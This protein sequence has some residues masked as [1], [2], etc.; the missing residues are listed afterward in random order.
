MK[1]FY[2]HRLGKMER[3]DWQYTRVIAEDVAPSEEFMALDQGF[4]LVSEMPISTWENLRST[5]ID[6]AR[7]RQP[8]LPVIS[9]MVLRTHAL[10]LTS[11]IEVY[12]RFIEARGFQPIE[13]DLEFMSRDMV[14]E[15]Q[16]DGHLV[17]FSKV[18]KY[19][20]AVELQL[21]CNLVEDK[22]FSFTTMMHEISMFNME[23]PYIYL[24]PGY[25]TSSIYKA[26]VSGF[27]WW[28]GREWSRD[29]AEYV[30]RCKAD[31]AFSL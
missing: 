5:R 1:I 2:D 3:S 10:P 14:I 31:S 30:T 6:I 24:G 16:R 22:A 28:T 11:Y 27:E 13:A 4:V 25:E 19:E 7:Y 12:D 9:G 17:G 29:T 21:H 18:R 23:Y 20:G 26:R 15:Y 8:E